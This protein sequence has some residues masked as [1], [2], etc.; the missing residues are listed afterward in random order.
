M[1]Y[2]FSNFTDAFSNA[3]GESKQ[4]MA[5]SQFS[6]I[7]GNSPKTIAVAIIDAGIGVPNNASMP[8]LIEIIKQ[9]RDNKKLKIHLGSLIVAQSEK[10]NFFGQKKDGS[11]ARWGTALFTR[12]PK[13]D[14][15]GAVIGGT[16]KPN[17]WK[18]NFGKTT[19]P[20]GTTAPSKF[21]S[22]FT[23]NQDT[24]GKVGGSLLSG[25]FKPK[26]TESATEQAEGYSGTEGAKAQES[27]GMGKKIMIGVAILGVVGLIIYL[28]KRK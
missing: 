1:I 20:D 22:W 13:L 7:L 18:R 16:E 8:T 23:K 3:D 28:A 19:N 17:F 12:K 26:G 11:G 4:R 6:K 14:S 10:S 2:E 27:G 9:N 21:G 15:A 25:L 5:I 24:I